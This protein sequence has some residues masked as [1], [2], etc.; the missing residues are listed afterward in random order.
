MQTN[1]HQELPS[2]A[3]AAENIIDAVLQ[4]DRRV[5]LFGPPGIGKS[6]LTTQLGRSLSEAGRDCWCVSADPGSPGFGVPGAVALARWVV[7]DWQI[8]AQEAL[9]TLDAGRFRLPLVSAVRRLVQAPFNGVVLVDGPGVVRGMAGRELLAGIIEAV[10]VDA[11][12]A[13]TAADR[14]PPLLDELRAL[15]PEVF[16]VH[17]ASDARRPGKRV[18]AQRRTTQWNDYLADT[19]ERQID[20]G[21]VNLIGTPPPASEK[22]A[23]I[24]RQLALIQHNKTLAMGEVL[25]LDDGVLTAL[26]PK[27]TTITD[28]VLVRDALRTPD[29]LIET[30]A[31][32]VSERL[33]YLSPPDVMPSVQENAG[34]RVVGRVGHV[35]ISLL[36]GVFGDPQLHLRLRHQGRSLLFDLGDGARLPARL[37]HQITDVF[38]SHAHM[39]HISG[40]QW[41]LRSRLGGLPACRIYGPPG[42]AHHIEG[43]IQCF[44]W[45]RIGDR[46]PIFQ[47]AELHGDRLRRYQLQAGGSACEPLDEMV[48]V[49]G[50]LHEESGF[51][52][53][54]VVLDHHTPV[55][56]YAFE[57]DQELNVRKDRLAAHGLAPGPWLAEL[58]QQ[59]LVGNLKA[60]VTLPDG[61]ARSVGDLGDELVLIKPGKRLVYATDLADT[62]ENRQRLTLLARGAHTFFCEAPFIEADAEQ[63]SRTGHLTTRAC[64]EI[65]SAAGVARLVPFHFSRRYAHNPQKVYEEINAACTCLVAPKTLK[66][67][68]PAKSVGFEKTQSLEESMEPSV[69]N[70]H[71]SCQT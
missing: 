3:C 12:L 22:A 21:K 20:L 33:D 36:N 4:Q 32:F 60:R 54:A 8:D 6:T 29:G 26:L 64:G 61:N 63:A 10:N 42:L 19:V 43:F 25:R 28:T 23:W 55:L 49:D 56:A 41:L 31:P 45:D 52:I 40:F 34:P 16:V 59:L 65:A 30:A 35:D 27:N 70:N 37:A 9:C 38:I 62:K 68:E 69:N 53:R 67:F 24:G 44:L 47:V 13:L 57:P 50:V 18:R 5:L 51:R 66:V 15:A 71:R 11:V 46:G 58:K 39:D 2:L 7:D 48:V 17:A 14:P 1:S